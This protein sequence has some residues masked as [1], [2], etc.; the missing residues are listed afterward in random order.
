MR[1]PSSNGIELNSRLTVSRAVAVL[2]G[3]WKLSHKTK[4]VPVSEMDVFTGRVEGAEQGQGLRKNR[5]QAIFDK[6]F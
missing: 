5:M 4:L 1:T 2:Y 6:F 3:G